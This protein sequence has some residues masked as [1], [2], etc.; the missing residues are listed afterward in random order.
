MEGYV[1]DEVERV[2]QGLLSILVSG[3]ALAVALL[4]LIG[5]TLTIVFE[6]YS[7][8]IV[9]RRLFGLGFFARY[10]E[11]LAV[12]AA[13]WAAQVIGALVVNA[14]GVSP[15]STD[16][17]ASVAPTATV[18]AVAAVVLGVEL[19]FSTAV[20]GLIERRNTVAVLKG[21]F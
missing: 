8:R 19:V 14:A 15:F 3:V 16:T 5:Q 18:L 21:D 1:A 4:V 13:L 6:R 2:H 17:T 9:M 10:A 12:M 11:Y 20:L 7:R